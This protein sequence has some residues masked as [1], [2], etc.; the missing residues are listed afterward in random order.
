MWQFFFSFVSAVFSRVAVGFIEAATGTTL[1]KV[2]GE[3]MQRIQFFKNSNI[4]KKRSDSSC[5][6]MKSA[7]DM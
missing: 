3:V 1:V 5:I 6:I 2:E 4:W 7:H